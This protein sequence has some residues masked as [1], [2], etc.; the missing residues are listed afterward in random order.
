MKSQQFGLTEYERR[1]QRAR[2]NELGCMIAIPV[3]LALYCIV[4]Y[5]IK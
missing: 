4:R 1:E 3:V 5:F 2:R